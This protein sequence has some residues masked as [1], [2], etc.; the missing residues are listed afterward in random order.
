[1]QVAGKDNRGGGGKAVQGRIDAATAACTNQLV[2][3][4]RRLSRGGQWHRQ[5]YQRCDVSVKRISTTAN[6]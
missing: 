3:I 2:A 1:M 5:R 4:V 6:A